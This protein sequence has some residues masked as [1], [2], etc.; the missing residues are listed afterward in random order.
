MTC[1]AGAIEK[2][3]GDLIKVG[4]GEAEITAIR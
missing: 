1:R 3:V 2:G 4:N